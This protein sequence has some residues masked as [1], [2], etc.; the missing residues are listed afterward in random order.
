MASQTHT[1]THTHTQS[2]TLI[3]ADAERVYTYMH[4][5]R[6]TVREMDTCCL[7]IHEH[8][9]PLWVKRG[10]AA[11]EQLMETD[12]ETEATS[13]KAGQRDRALLATQYPIIAARL[14]PSDLL[15]HTRKRDQPFS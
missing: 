15:Q 7:Y 14:W 4:K 1:H 2:G 12:S 9:P 8:T 3:K 6:E 5:S 11:P 10:R 13:A